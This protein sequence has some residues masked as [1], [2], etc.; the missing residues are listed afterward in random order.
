MGGFEIRTNRSRHSGYSGLLKMS[1][2]QDIL[3]EVAASTGRQWIML[4]I[5]IVN[6]TFVIIVVAH[7][8]TC[9]WWG[10]W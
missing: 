4:V 1:K 6:T 7:V 2:L 10:L 3:Q 5:A 9:M 8:L